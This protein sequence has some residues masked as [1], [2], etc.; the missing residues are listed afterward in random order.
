MQ[1]ISMLE[2]HMSYLSLI[3]SKLNINSPFEG[4]E[5]FQ[6]LRSAPIFSL[7]RKDHLYTPA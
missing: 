6:L 3:L 4:S 2:L 5:I 1:N 7:Q